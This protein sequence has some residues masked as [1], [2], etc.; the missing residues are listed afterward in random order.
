MQQRGFTLIEMILTIVVGGILV[1]GIAG[2][3]ELGARGYADT[4]DRQRLQTQAKFVLEKMAREVRHAVPNLFRS[5]DNCVYFYPIIYSGFYAISG[6]DI[7]FIVGQR[8]DLDASSFNDLAMIINPTTNRTVRDDSF[9]LT[10][11]VTALGNQVFSVAN[12]VTNLTSESVAKRFYIFHPNQ[13][14]RYCIASV[15]G[16]SRVERDGA[17]LSDFVVSGSLNYQPATVQNNG[18]VH[19]NLTFSQNGERTNFEQEIQVINVP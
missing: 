7:E 14:R 16:R 5:E 10:G 6:N 19:A 3:V 1:L 15:A 17:P 8:D 4:V 13:E 12:Q 11:Q 9:S 18:L 2:F